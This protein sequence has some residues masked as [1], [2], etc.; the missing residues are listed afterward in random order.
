[1]KNDFM[2][3]FLLALF[4]PVA[5]ALALENYTIDGNSIASQG[6]VY[7][8]LYKAET[9]FDSKGFK[10]FVIEDQTKLAMLQ[11][12]LQKLKDEKASA[13][14]KIE[15]LQE[16]SMELNETLSK[17]EGTLDILERQK[18]EMESRVSELDA[19]I[20]G[21]EKEIASLEGKKESLE[22]EISANIV[23]SPN[24]YRLSVGFFII[25]LLAVVV[26]KGKDFLG[27][28][29]EKKKKAQ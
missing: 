1:M 26:V 25:L 6:S 28:E 18:D 15:E 20:A 10:S 11:E 24:A 4:V 12:R 22:S 8:I 9:F 5:H 17:A 2:I 21:L 13:E 29:K 27:E 16:M 3:I 14:A 23:V 19:E 7:K